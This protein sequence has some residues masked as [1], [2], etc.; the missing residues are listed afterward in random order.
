M[1]ATMQVGIGFHFNCALCNFDL[2]THCAD[3][4]P[5]AAALRH[6][7]YPKCFFQFLPYPPGDCRRYC[8]A[9]GQDIGGFVY[10]SRK[11][12]CDLH[13]CCAA[14]PHVLNAD[15]GLRLHLRHKTSAP[16]DKGGSNGDDLSDGMAMVLRNKFPIIKAEGNNRHRSWK[17][18]LKKYSKLAVLAVKFI[19][20]AML[21]D[22]TTLIAGV[23]SSLLS[24]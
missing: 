21:G 23:V 12:G 6:S 1:V 18:K 13:P 17:G 11:C 10:H 4:N 20:A 3:A 5:N 16:C 7:F 15:G 9:C 8:N 19:I 2:H 24:E 14:L 22:P